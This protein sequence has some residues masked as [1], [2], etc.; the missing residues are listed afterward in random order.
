VSKGVYEGCSRGVVGVWKAWRKVFARRCLEAEVRNTAA[1]HEL[2]ELAVELQ[3]A[4]GLLL[5]GAYT[6]PLFGSP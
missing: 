1:L 2:E 6:R 4:D 3:V 5:P